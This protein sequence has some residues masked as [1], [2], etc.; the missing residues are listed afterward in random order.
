[1]ADL[2]KTGDVVTAEKLNR[3]IFANMTREADDPENPSY[4]RTDIR[5]ADV[6]D[7]SNMPVGLV[8]FVNAGADESGSGG[9]EYAFTNVIAY[10]ATD[11]YHIDAVTLAGSNGTTHIPLFAASRNDYFASARDNGEPIGGT[12]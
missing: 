12:R 6:F 8:I 7:E 1:M 11:G 10:N 3:I 5:P 4:Y 9:A 2:W